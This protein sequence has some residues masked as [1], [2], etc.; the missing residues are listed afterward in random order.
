M[1]ANTTVSHIVAIKAKIL[2]L[3]ER[4]QPMTTDELVAHNT[5]FRTESVRYSIDLL[6]KDKKVKNVGRHNA[7][8]WALQ[9][10]TPE[11]EP[12]TK[13]Y[14]SG[15]AKPKALPKKLIKKKPA[16]DNLAPG[17]MINKMAGVYV[18]TRTQPMRPG[19]TDHESCMSRRADGL[20]RHTGQ[21]IAIGVKAKSTA[22]TTA[23]KAATATMR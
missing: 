12:V 1:Q 19:A 16:T 11:A 7:A 13:R 14:H 10:Y 6:R 4:R 9:D 17:T 3:L 18:P 23:T 2:L 22:T 8:L 21:Y 20:V 5:E 15:R